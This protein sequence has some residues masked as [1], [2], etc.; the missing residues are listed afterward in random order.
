MGRVLHS[1]ENKHVYQD[2]ITTL[3]ITEAQFKSALD[4][5]LP[6]F[7]MGKITE[8]EFW[9]RFFTITNNPLPLPDDE[10]LWAREFR[11]RYRV[12]DDVMHV[13][14]QLKQ[15]GYQIAILSNSIEPHAEVNEEMG[16]YTPFPTVVLSHEV[17]MIK[18]DPEIYLYTL[19]KLSVNPEESIFIDDLGENIEA[20]RNL[21]MKG[22]VFENCEQMKQELV[23]FGIPF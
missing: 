12:F 20:A 11:K 2:I 21:G 4:V 14:D 10:S 22:I 19:K 5:L 13:V 17:G 15:L 6:L 16:V 3:G 1:S 9:K 7:L 23:S 8:A 18:P